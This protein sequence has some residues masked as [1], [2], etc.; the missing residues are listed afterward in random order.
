MLPT[1][2]YS[3]T[4]SSSILFYP[5]AYSSEKKILKALVIDY[6]STNK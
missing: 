2:E 1:F 6:Y 4:S 3:I 5:N